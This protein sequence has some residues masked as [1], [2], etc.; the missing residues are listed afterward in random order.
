MTLYKETSFIKWVKWII[1][2]LNTITW[3]EDR[4]YENIIQEYS[5]IEAQFIKNKDYVTMDNSF[6]LSEMW[7]KIEETQHK[8]SQKNLKINLVSLRDSIKLNY[9][10]V[11]ESKAKN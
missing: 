9:L 8:Y 5:F 7:I 11:I 4:D 6:I 3:H 2:M 10:K 1:D